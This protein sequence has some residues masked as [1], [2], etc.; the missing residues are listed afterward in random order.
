MAPAEQDGTMGYADAEHYACLT[1]QGPDLVPPSPR[2]DAFASVPG[3]G[4]SGVPPEEDCEGESPPCPAESLGLNP[5]DHGRTIIFFPYGWSWDASTRGNAQSWPQLAAY[6][7][8][9]PAGAVDAR[10]YDDPFGH[11]AGY[12]VPVRPLERFTQYTGSV[13]WQLD[14]GEQFTQ[15]VPFTTGDLLPEDRPQPPSTA[16]IGP[17]LRD[18]RL[19]VRLTHLGR[20]VSV[21]ATTVRRARGT[22]GVVARRGHSAQRLQP[23]KSRR[24]GADRQS[25]YG[26]MLPRGRWKVVVRF[27]GSSGWA[28]RKAT[29]AVRI[30]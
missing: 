24:S 9:G 16:P 1:L 22:L 7:L 5:A 10:W 17:G 6:S 21:R 15:T 28:S 23:L 27:A 20:R 3:A 25:T 30:R 18:P 8:M 19:R 29:R 2:L 14:T 26:A 13:S 4:T 12:L 11:L